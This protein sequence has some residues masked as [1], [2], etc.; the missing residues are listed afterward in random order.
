MQSYKGVFEAHITLAPLQVG[1]AFK[2][3]HFCQENELKPVQIELSRGSH[4]LQQMTASVHEG[5]YENVLQEVQGIAQKLRIEGFNV[6]RIKLEASP[7]NEGLPE[8]NAETVLHAAENYFEHHLKLLLPADLGKMQTTLEHLC[9][10]HQ[11]HLSRNAFKKRQD[12]MQERFVTLRH[13][14]L[15]RQEAY[16]ALHILRSCLE[17]ASFQVLKI[18][19][20]YCV[21]DDHV[22]LDSNW[23]TLE[24]QKT[25]LNTWETPCEVCNEQN[26]VLHYAHS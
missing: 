15:G 10:Q 20:E 12:G 14:G 4:T 21:Y 16:E 13:Y 2:F 23:L 7:F 24:S 9:E 25:P 11:A 22:A 5:T 19:S 17:K 6:T 1:E 8:N 18:I 26:C 3:M